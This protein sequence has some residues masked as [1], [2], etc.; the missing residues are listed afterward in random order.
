[1]SREA[2]RQLPNRAARRVD[3]LGA[4]ADAAAACVDED[5]TSFAELSVERLA[6]RAGISRASFYL[7]FEDKGELVRGWHQEFDAQVTAGYAEWWNVSSPGRSAVSGALEEL[8]VIHRRSRTVLAAIQQMTAHDPHLR[9]ERVEA[10]QRKRGELR[11]HIMRGQRENWIDADLAPDTTAAWLIS[12]V[13]R[14]M[15][16]VVPTCGDATSLIDTGAEIVWRALYASPDRR[17]LAWGCPSAAPAAG[18]Q[19]RRR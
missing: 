2:R 15:Q 7:Y 6:R 16:Q 14:V 5:N 17:D 3:T 4:L 1:M 9:H 18:R 19:L 12:M 8:A 13:D 11:R 10:F